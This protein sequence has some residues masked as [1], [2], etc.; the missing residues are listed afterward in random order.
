MDSEFVLAGY[1]IAELIGFGPTGEVWRAREVATGETVALKRLR[2]QAMAVVDQLRREAEEVA[3][4]GG[5]HVLAVR[6]VV[7]TDRDVVLVLP[8]ATGGSL[9]DLIE[10]RGPLHPGETVTVF[11]PLAGAMAALHERGL[12]HGD[13]T[14]ANILLDADGRPMLA[15]WGIAVALD[16]A[17]AATDGTADYLDPD[18]LTGGTPSSAGDVYSLAACAFAALAG[19]PP[20]IG[21]DRLAAFCPD[22]PTELIDT[23][24]AGLA[25]DLSRRSGA[26]EFAAGLL[27]ATA[28]EPVAQRRSV[29]RPEPPTRRPETPRRPESSQRRPEPP[30]RRPNAAG[31]AAPA[32]RSG[33]LTPASDRAA[34]ERRRLPTIGRVAVAGI[35]AFGL[36]VLAGAAWSHLHPRAVDPTSQASPRSVTASTVAPVGLRSPRPSPTPS[37]ATAPTPTPVATSSAAVWRGIVGYLESTR[38]RAFATGQVSLLDAVYTADA[39]D[40]AADR[41]SVRALHA[42]GLRASGFA[43][44]VT[45]VTVQ[46]QT[47]TA[48]TL[49]V[50]DRLAAY[51]LVAAD[52]SVVGSGRGRPAQAFTMVLADTS[53]GWRVSQVVP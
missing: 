15:D 42:R 35:F 16:T 27:A 3:A 24:E 4:A 12:V 31:P 39:P 30:P 14:P 21:R 25:A 43:A 36:S 48:A 7:V 40:L 50:V 19:R 8:I 18:V 9:A 32:R 52:G 20:R 51:R 53:R 46:K 23:V 41:A 29:R 22:A 11:A 17:L 34:E 5:D 6:E 26:A 47:A 38:A 13:L 1:E 45:D 28:A 37:G 2:P 33:R 44:T 49:Q 10:R